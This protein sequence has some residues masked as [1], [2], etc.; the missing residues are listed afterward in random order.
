MNRFLTHL[1]TWALTVVPAGMASCM[2]RPMADSLATQAQR[3]YAAGDHAGALA[4]F[5]SVNTVWTSAGL[6]Y[7]IGNCHYKL[8]HM[9]K[10][11]LHYERALKLE[12]GA[13]DVKAG[14]ELA[15]QQ[16]PDRI[17]MPAEGPLSKAWDRLRGGSDPDHWARWALWSCLLC[18]L[19]LAVPA[20]LGKASA[21]RLL[22]PVAGLLL[23]TTVISASLAALRAREV[24]THEEGIIM[25]PK[26]ELRSEPRS[27]GTVLFV[28]HKGSKVRIQHTMEG[29]HEVRLPNGS[30]GWMPQE[31]LERI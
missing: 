5:D 1:V 8:G 21:R 6:E 3:A 29:W 13:E 26:V 18:A 27:S 19:A 15:R 20:I 16:I 23:L 31:A 9:P 22:L 4:L 11:I 28:L 14:L 12:P 10:A 25:S 2:D 7:N 30:V 24:R 17:S